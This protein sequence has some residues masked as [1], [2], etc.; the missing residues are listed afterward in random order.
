MPLEAA[1]SMVV[2]SADWEPDKYQG[3][4]ESSMKAPSCR[5]WTSIAV[6]ISMGLG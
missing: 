2:G 1:F 3:S 6:G 5:A 4:D